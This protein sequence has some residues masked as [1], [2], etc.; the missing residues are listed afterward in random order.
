[1]PKILLDSSRNDLDKNKILKNGSDEV[2][3]STKKFS[4]IS[5]NKQ[6]SGAQTKID[7]ALETLILL[8]L[9]KQELP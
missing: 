8:N 4:N 5:H 2:L 9:P 6:S 3:K 1:M 7:R